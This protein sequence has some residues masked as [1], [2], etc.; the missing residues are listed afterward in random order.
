MD[1]ERALPM[2]VCPGPSPP[3]SVMQSSSNHCSHDGPRL[4]IM[5]KLFS[6]ICYLRRS[7][8]QDARMNH[9]DQLRLAT[10]RCCQESYAHL[11]IPNDDLVSQRLWPVALT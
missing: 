2:E 9:K 10:A 7:W 8:Y 3:M 1:P 6:H 5:V 4:E 11:C